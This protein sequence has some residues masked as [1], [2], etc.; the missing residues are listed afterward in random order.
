[1]FF[2]RN[3]RNVIILCYTHTLISH[4][5]LLSRCAHT[6]SFDGIAILKNSVFKYTSFVMTTEAKKI[7]IISGDEALTKKL[8]DL[9]TQAGYESFV[10]TELVT[11]TTEI[12]RVQPHLVILD[13]DDR[14][15]DALLLLETLHIS[16]NRRLRQIPVIVGFENGNILEIGRALKM[17]IKDYF[18]TATFDSDDVM[19]KVKKCFESAGATLG[20]S[21]AKVLMVED[22]KFL[23]ELA[24]QKFTKEGLKAISAMDGM[25]GIML[26]EKELPDAILL[27]I[28][29]PGIDGFE[30]LKRIRA[31]PALKKTPVFMLSNFGQTEDIQKSKDLGADQFL[32]KADHTLD[33]IVTMV[34]EH[35]VKSKVA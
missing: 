2:F 17:G 31:N 35:M 12:E 18:I 25:Q 28:L 32:V 3:A 29:L 33:E 4:H 23:R 34:R 27:D 30:V 13:F 21:A 22:D 5:S 15:E 19:K 14:T 20:V 24:T 6:Q 16:P 8:P 9:L 11:A 10:T 1:M 7:L 26:A